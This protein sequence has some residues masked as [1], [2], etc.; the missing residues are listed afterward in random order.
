MT[1]A[2][3]SESDIRTAGPG[4]ID[5]SFLKELDQKVNVPAGLFPLV[6]A[7]NPSMMAVTTAEGQYLE[8]NRAFCEATGYTRDELLG[9]N[10]MQLGEWKEEQRQ[11]IL[12]SLSTV[13]KVRNKEIYWRNKSGNVHCCILSAEVVEFE[14]EPLVLSAL[15]DITKRK[16]M[17]DE[18]RKSKDSLAL[19]AEKL[20]ALNTALKV[21]LDQQEQNQRLTSARLKSNMQELITPY[22]ERLKDGQMAPMDR[23]SLSVLES[24]LMD[25]SSDFVYNLASCYPNLTPKEIQVANLVKEGKS[26]GE[27]AHVMG[28]SLGTVNAHRNNLRRKMKLGKGGAN[29]RSHLLAMK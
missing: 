1:V 2:R 20:E 25:I 10:S 28:V 21:L 6:F 19:Q 14:G 16:Q 5:I 18:L 7:M 23:V 9:Q 8:V 22:L 26:S 24:N 13:G 12:T 3:K 15:H 11:E 27:I 4:G 29:L 17:E